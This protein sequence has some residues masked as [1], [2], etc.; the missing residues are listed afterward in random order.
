M[1][2]W[3]VLICWG[4]AHDMARYRAR[5]RAAT[6]RTRLRR[7]VVAWFRLGGADGVSAEATQ[8]TVAQLSSAPQGWRRQC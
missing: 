5:A 3:L 4:V 8:L 7:V 6:G 1:G 2:P